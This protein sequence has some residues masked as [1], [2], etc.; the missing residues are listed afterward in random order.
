MSNPASISLVG[1]EAP[2]AREVASHVEPPHTIYTAIHPV[3]ETPIR[4]G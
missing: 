1:A 2:A 4:S 3:G